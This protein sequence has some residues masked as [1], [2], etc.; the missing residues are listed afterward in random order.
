MSDLQTIAQQ[1]FDLVAYAEDVTAKTKIYSNQINEML[2][3]INNTIH[4][5][6]Y[7]E[8]QELINRLSDSQAKIN[9]VIECLISV[10][11]HGRDWLREHVSVGGTER[12]RLYNQVNSFVST[13][14]KINTEDTFK[15]TRKT[16]RNLSVSQYGFSKDKTGMEIYDSPLEIDKYLYAK[17]GSADENFKGTCGLCACANVLRLAGVNYGEKEMI[18][19]ASK[20]QGD[21]FSQPLC[22]VKWYDPFASGGTTPEERKQILEHFGINSSVVDVKTYRN[23]KVSI[24]TINDIAEWVSEGR[25]VII[26]VDGGL[27][28]D[29]PKK[30]GKG[31]AVTITSVERNKYGDITAFYILDSNR[32]TVKYSSCEIQEMVRNWIGINVTNQIIR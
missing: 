32:G 4:G 20:R 7:R 6:S 21:F 29:D 25:G 30:N 9:Y 17:Q 15:P 28:Y 16:P 23:G 24:D 13:V 2:I 27:F 26:D 22:T 14:A 3:L 11:E 5:T 10:S 18:D 31:H 1:I 19:Y 12:G 8:Y